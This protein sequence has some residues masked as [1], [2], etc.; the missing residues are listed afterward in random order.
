[1]MPTTASAAKRIAYFCAATGKSGR[2]NRM[3]PYVPIFSSVPAS[4]IEPPVGACTCA[5]GSHVWNGKS[6]TLTENASANR[7]NSHVCEPSGT[8]YES[9]LK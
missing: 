1:M 9:S 2:Q 3:S 5:S 7:K 6:G 8:L 4:T